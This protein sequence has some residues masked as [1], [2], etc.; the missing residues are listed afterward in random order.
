M[1]AEDQFTT[2]RG[3]TELRKLDMPGSVCSG[4]I[5]LSQFRCA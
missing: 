4:R 1:S 5:R 3:D 2:M